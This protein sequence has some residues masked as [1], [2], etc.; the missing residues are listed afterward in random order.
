MVM[1][2]T[3]TLHTGPMGDFPVWPSMCM[4]NYREMGAGGCHKKTHYGHPYLFCSLLLSACCPVPWLDVTTC[5]HFWS[6]SFFYSLL[7]L[8]PRQ[9][10]LHH[11]LGLEG[12]AMETG[13]R[14][15]GACGGYGGALLSCILKIPVWLPPS[16]F[17]LCC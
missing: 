10:A 9:P 7:C 1:S 6:S 14:F 8:L 17:S 5:F 12:D 16:S 4:L 3:L 2:L 15:L 13:Q 11:P